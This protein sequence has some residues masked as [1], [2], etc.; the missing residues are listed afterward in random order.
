M[1][2]EAVTFANG[3]TATLAACAVRIPAGFSTRGDL[4]KSFTAWLPAAD[5]PRDPEASP[6][7]IASSLCEP[8][9]KGAMDGITERSVERYTELLAAASQNTEE[10]A[11]AM[12]RSFSCGSVCGIY[13]VVR[14]SGSRNY[15]PT[16]FL[17]GGT[18][19][20]HIR[21]NDPTI[22]EEKILSFLQQWMETVKP[23]SSWEGSLPLDD[24]RFSQGTLTA[25]SLAAFRTNMEQ[26]MHEEAVCFQLGFRIVQEEIRRAERTGT[27]DADTILDE[28]KTVREDYAKAL[29]EVIRE[30][31]SCIQKTSRNNP[32]NELLFSLVQTIRDVNPLDQV[33]QTIN[34]EEYAAPVSLAPKKAELFSS[35]EI[36]K[37]EEAR[38]E[39]EEKA[40]AVREKQM[41]KERSQIRDK[42]RELNREKD[43]L[44]D[45]KER[46]AEG[47]KKKKEEFYT[48]LPDKDAISKKLE[49]AGGV[50]TALTAQR[51]R[52]S[53]LQRRKKRE[54]EKQLADRQQEYSDCKEALLAAKK[55]W[56]D[57]DRQWDE[58]VTL[59]KGKTNEIDARIAELDA[60]V[61]AQETELESLN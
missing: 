12:Q 39:E 1:K 25:E 47:L 32:D 27:P 37:M 8:Y 16:V 24:D 19:Q 48:G 29:D 38:R 50:V 13:N 22:P 9:A 17:P 57:R 49:E 55:A 26:R 56:A 34:G 7:V 44:N 59:E 58:V 31:A 33:T 6:F 51:E 52:L 15:Y 53:F 41:E 21:V 61:A 42:I 3:K 20:F 46:Q 4:K 45:Q 43:S 10:D 23:A 40:A 5:A 54:L 60:Q 18:Q 14:F 11:D 2:L 28:L 36:R 35:P 30:S